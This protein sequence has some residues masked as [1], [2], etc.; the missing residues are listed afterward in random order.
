MRKLI[1]FQILDI[2]AQHYGVNF[3]ELMTN[4]G[5]Q[6]AKYIS[7]NTEPT[8]P[9]KFICGHGNNGGDGF[10]AAGILKGE[11]FDVEVY[12]VKEPKTL[13]SK[14][15]LDN[16]NGNIQ[17]IEGIMDIKDNSPLIVDCLLGS[18]IIGDPHSPYKEIIDEVNQF[19]NIISV[20]VPSGFGTAISVKPSQTV[21]F[22]EKK[23]GMNQDNC[24]EIIVVDVG[25]SSDVDELTGPGEL[26]LFPDFDSKK[27]KGQNGKV[28]IIGGGEYSGAPALA[29]IGA[30]RSGV[31]LVHV[32]VP[33]VS[34]NQVSSFAPEL[35][36]HNLNGNRINKD[37]LAIINKDEFDS[38]VIGPGMGK[39]KESIET[40]Q[41]VI[42]N[43][44][45]VVIDA[46]A[47]D[48]YNFRKN[49][50]LLTPHSGELTRLKIGNDRANLME[51]A[52]SNN[53]S[54][55]LKGKKDFITNGSY[56]KTNTTGHPRMAVGGTGDLLSG[57]CGGLMARDLSPFEAGR[58]AAYALGKAGELC[59][60]EYGV[61]FLPTDLGLCISKVLSRK[62]T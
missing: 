46:D 3:F 53:L 45:N 55:L 27:H 41:A 48:I 52:K 62:Y 5:T 2:N 54:L 14:K 38:I 57:L 29:A 18:G 12:Y 47:I 36:V 17:K 35:I 21:T 10:V 61:G 25:F 23:R 33:E 43:F 11:G 8:I 13:T 37:V 42:D 7:D 24:G 19:E 26:L 15:A 6:V 39:H 20:D 9:L 50:I 1:E 30:Y 16:Y 49:N 60:E 34:Y 58:L 51:F 22:H 59:F 40:V 31:D 28:A 32:F 56:F 4:A 44:E